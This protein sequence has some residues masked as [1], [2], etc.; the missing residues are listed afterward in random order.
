MADAPRVVALADDPLAR[1]GL[2]ALVA[3]MG[4]ELAATGVTADLDAV[5]SLADDVDAVVLAIGPS[6]EPEVEAI[7]ELAGGAA[8][9]IVLVS[10]ARHASIAWA[11]GADAVLSADAGPRRLRAAHDAARAGLRVVDG[12]L[13]SMVAFGA[14][15]AAAPGAGLE[16]E[17]TPR[18]AE[19]LRLMAEGLPNKTI[20]RRMG[21]SENTV[22]THANAVLAKLGAS[23]RTEAAIRAARLGLV[24]L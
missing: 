2:A 14:P 10:E 21:I 23:S 3:A 4:A 15:S 1:S 17:L 11:A 18:E 22:K 5:E 8:A 9:L 19:V 6:A 20:A 16:E 12:R 24:S 13:A 7:G